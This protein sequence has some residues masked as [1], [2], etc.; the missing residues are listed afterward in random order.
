MRLD[1]S[2]SMHEHQ[3]ANVIAPKVGLI[4]G[5]GRYPIVV[6]EALHEQGSEVVCLGVE[7]HAD[8]LLREMCDAY[9]DI[10]I[11]KLG[12]AIRYF[13]QQGVKRAT[14][15]GKFHKTLLMQKHWIKH[16]PDWRA[17][18]TFFPHFIGMSK[19]RKDDTLLRAIV[20]AFAEDGIRFV[21]ATEY[22]PEILV[23]A[24]TMT[25]RQPSRAEL[26]DI[27]F[28]WTIAKKIGEVDIGQSVAV[29]GRAILA[30]EAIEGTDAC[31]R[32]AGELCKGGGFTLVKV[33]KP[34]Q[35]MRF[36]VPTIGMGTVES[37]VKAGARVLAVEAD[38]TIFLD[39]AE[40][41]DFANQ[42]QLAI[43]ALR[44][45]AASGQLREAA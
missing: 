24:G 26:K 4:A 8:P 6:A 18:R 38:K 40:V 27:E 42:H 25:K 33:A 11:G 45:D 7:Q 14:M 13:R 1:N 19:D 28:G 39:Q 35:D 30:V 23:K 12:G 32:R 16:L 10:G 34:K 44:C 20:E 41:I 22:V 17:V 9:S 37:L 5:W 29:K 21:P 43:V 36:D 3:H 2:V 15:A 31:I